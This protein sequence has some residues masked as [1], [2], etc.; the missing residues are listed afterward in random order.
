MILND[1]TLQK[2][3]ELMKKIKEEISS[4]ETYLKY[5]PKNDMST[6]GI[7]LHFMCLKTKLEM[8]DEIIN[9]T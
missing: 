5:L 8:I 4:L 7:F 1:N 3:N 6:A 2:L 9:D